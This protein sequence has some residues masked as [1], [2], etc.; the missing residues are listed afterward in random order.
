MC[1]CSQF[2]KD[3]RN[4]GKTPWG[5]YLNVIAK[6]ICRET[7]ATYLLWLKVI[8]SIGLKYSWLRNITDGGGDFMDMIGCGLATARC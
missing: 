2:V 3:C 5:A 4:L 8:A 6:F 1:N 7:L